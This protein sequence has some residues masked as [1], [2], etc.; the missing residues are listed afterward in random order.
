MPLDPTATATKALMHYSATG[1]AAAF[2]QAADAAESTG[3]PRA[4]LIGR[5]LR[6]AHKAVSGAPAKQVA[7]VGSIQGFRSLCR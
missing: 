2:K 5:L 4:P 1:E 3:H 7:N 6:A